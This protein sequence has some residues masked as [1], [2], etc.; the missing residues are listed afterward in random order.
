MGQLIKLQDYISRYEMDP[1][2]Y[3]A[4]Y[5]RMKKQ[6]WDKLK[7]Q[8][9]NRSD[10][11][12]NHSPQLYI[13][14]EEN[15]IKSKN[16][17]RRLFGKVSSVQE[18][19]VIEEPKKNESLFHFS[20]QL[21]YY[22]DTID[23][24]KQL[25]LDQL[26]SFQMKWASSTIHE[27][28]YPDQSYFRNERLKY[29]LQ[30]FPDTFLFLY[31]PIFILKKAPI[32]MEV[33]LITPTEVWCL[34]FL[35]EE[36]EA[37]FLG[38]NSRFW[39]KRANNKESKVLNPLLSLNRM[40]KIISQLLTYYSLEIPLKKAIICRNGYIDYPTAPTDV[41]LLEKRNYPEWFEQQRSLQSPLKHV[42]LKTAKVLLDY[43]QTKSARRID[44]DNKE[45][46]Y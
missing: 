15:K 27:K 6:Q 1:Y 39:I 38:S 26:F 44:W 31:E 20:P 19:S 12:Q 41:F 5:V 14:E 28:S 4:Q 18:E 23:E 3:P 34:A 17:F 8:W 36:K 37:V 32:E 21:A 29:F 10:D 40:S 25:F 16:V 33:I 7:D 42:Q 24:L 45:E 9:E 35:E 46:S 2:R 13:N 43:C 30:R 22:P 11:Y